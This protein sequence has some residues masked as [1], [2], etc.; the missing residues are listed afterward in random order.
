MF[1][2]LKEPFPLE[3]N[4]A[5]VNQRLMLLSILVYFILVVFKPFGLKDHHG[6][7]LFIYAGG[8]VVLGYLYLWFHFF[9]VES[10]FNES[11]WT[12]GKEILNNL[13]ILIIIGFINAIYFSL[14]EDDSISLVI[15]IAFEIYTLAIGIIPVTVNIILRQNRLMKYHT[16]VAGQIDLFDRGEK[17]INDQ[18]CRVTLKGINPIKEYSFKCND[19]I[20]ME[21]RDNYILLYYL[22]ENQI[23][24][25]LIR[26]TMK[27]CAQEVNRYPMFFRCHRSYIV[28]LNKI[29]SIEGNA[30]GLKLKL[31]LIEEKIPV[32]RLLVKEFKT[33][34]KQLAT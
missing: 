28:N 7:D 8:F 27:Q 24:K 29:K 11:N 2:I 26:N 32:S 30:Q 34:M 13:L 23:H 9:V 15:I 10:W 18:E 14:Y 5:K 25:E 22:V 6:S 12:L 21:A 31:Q 16:K 33:R 1:K 3:K 4:L 17:N 19:L 20:L